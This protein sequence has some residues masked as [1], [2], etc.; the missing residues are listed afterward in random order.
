[1]NIKQAKI[2]L[3]NQGVKVSESSLRRLIREGELIGVNKAN[4]KDGW[5]VSK[6]SLIE[7]ALSTGQMS[8]F[9]AYQLGYYQGVEKNKNECILY[10]GS[11]QQS[12][13]FQSEEENYYCVLISDFISGFF[14]SISLK[15]NDENKTLYL[16]DHLKKGTRL[17]HLI[18][19]GIIQDIILKIDVL[20]SQEDLY[21]YKV[22]LCEETPVCL[23]FE[24]EILESRELDLSEWDELINEDFLLFNM[25]NKKEKSI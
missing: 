16:I 15:I 2:F 24:K 6:S 19:F 18:N 25:K 12:F 3:N 17:L 1:M 5:D 10:Q 14:K 4:N 22:I 7:Y 8:S 23:F 9:S 21:D 13:V 11:G 20:D